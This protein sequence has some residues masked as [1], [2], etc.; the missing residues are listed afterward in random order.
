[1]HSI[2]LKTQGLAK[3]FGAPKRLEHGF[4][5]SLGNTLLLRMRAVDL[6]CLRLISR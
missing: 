6:P 1:M 2:N 4:A 3:E 5:E